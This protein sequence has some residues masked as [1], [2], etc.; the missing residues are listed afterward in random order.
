[1][2]IAFKYTELPSNQAEPDRLKTRRD[3]YLWV[4]KRTDIHV[5]LL[6]HKHRRPDIISRSA[7]AATFHKGNVIVSPRVY[8]THNTSFVQTVFR[9][10]DHE[11]HLTLLAYD[12]IVL[13]VVRYLQPVNECH[14]VREEC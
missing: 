2:P 11:N 5:T 8:Y 10:G 12:N 4:S 14:F 6:R 9:C 13:I 1:M 7:L 3:T